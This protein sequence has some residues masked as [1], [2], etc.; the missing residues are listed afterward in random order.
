[1]T[2]LKKMKVFSLSILV[3][4]CLSGCFSQRV[5]PTPA[6]SITAIP[7]SYTPTGTIVWFPPTA[8]ATIF[9]TPYITPTIDLRPQAGD[10]ILFDDFTDPA[11]WQLSYSNT[12]SVALGNQEITL[13]INQPSGYL[14]TLRNEPYLGNF[15][16]E[17]TA[18][19]SLC[20]GEDEYG[21]LLRVSPS[22]DFYRF[23][24]SCD[25]QT[26]LDKY[27]QGRASSPQPFMMSGAI[28]PGA[29][30][31]SR[32]AVWAQGKEMHFFAN[33]EHLFS[34]NDPSITAGT[35]GL[36]IR[37]AGDNA[38]TV[39][40]SELEIFSADAGPALLEVNPNEL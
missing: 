21:L 29:P 18:S 35:I 40:F 36:F 30:S 20:R 6:P 8:T 13:A 1:M 26:R 11:P 22:L 16:L 24:L 33:S 17:I 39:S 32:I 27:F 19:P 37:S 25:G 14:F 34:V 28:P 5:T 3:I 4:I 15:Y 38:V 7:V 2:R 12:T 23:S 31:Q 10:I 9:P